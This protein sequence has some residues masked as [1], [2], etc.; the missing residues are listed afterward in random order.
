MKTFLFPLILLFTLNGFS[1][2]LFQY[3]IDE[4]MSM[5]VPDDSG[6]GEMSGQTFIRGSIGDDT[7]IISKTSKGL[8]KL[9]LDKN[10]DLTKFYEGVKGGILK[11][12]RGRVVKDT[13]VEIDGHKVLNFVYSMQVEGQPKVVDSY[14]WVYKK[15]TYTIQ[16]VSPE[17]ESENFKTTRKQ[18][19]ESIDL[20]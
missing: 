7:F 10:P 4:N 14:I 15:L 16:F 18:I 6:E 11:S 12:S 17:V 1:Q 8:D 5:L 3:D 19:L 2:E 20:K 9:N 13:M